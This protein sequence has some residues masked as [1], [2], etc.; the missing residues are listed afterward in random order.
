MIDIRAQRWISSVTLRINPFSTTMHT[1]TILAA[2][3]AVTV[4]RTTEAVAKPGLLGYEVRA[5][6]KKINSNIYEFNLIA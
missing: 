1:L 4:S 6:R 3:L 5:L 2:V